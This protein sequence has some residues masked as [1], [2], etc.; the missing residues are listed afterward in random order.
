MQRF[1]T[2]QFRTTLWSVIEQAA[3]EETPD[4]SCARETL[5]QAY[6]YPLYV[7]IRRKGHDSEAAK[8]LTQA[9]F[10]HLLSNSRLK[11]IN[12]GKGKFRT[13][14]LCAL[15]NF[16]L[17]EWDRGRRLKRGAG[18]TLLPFDAENPEGRYELESVHDYT[19]ER[20]F[21]RQWAKTLVANVLGLM[22]AEVESGAKI[23]RF[24]GLKGFLLGDSATFTSYAEAAF[25]LDMTEQGVKCAVLR[26]RRHFRDLLRQQIAATVSKP[27]EVDEEIRYLLRVLAE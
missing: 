17:N 8:D 14:L 4:G 26:L 16:L 25:H 15:S 10:L 18:Y 1:S 9:F 22:R 19:P 20:A 12:R 3:D 24:D 13:F 21:D 6:W 5:C 27:Q 11:T 23:Q 2:A 7:F